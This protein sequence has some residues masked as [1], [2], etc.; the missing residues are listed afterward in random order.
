MSSKMLSI[1]LIV[2]LC[3][4]ESYG[5][6]VL[7][8]PK[9]MCG[10]SEFKLECLSKKKCES[11]AQFR[12]YNFQSTNKEKTKCNMDATGQPKT[13]EFPN[14]VYICKMVKPVQS[15]TVKKIKPKFK[16]TLRVLFTSLF[17]GLYVYIS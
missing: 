10:E 16:G 15:T 9:K 2:I 3:I 4:I 5:D 6:K 13:A 1:T 8:N 14:G 12:G 7:C 17:L 11:N